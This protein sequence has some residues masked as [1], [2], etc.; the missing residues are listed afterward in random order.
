MAVEESSEEQKR[1]DA[2]GT[3]PSWWWR[4][5]PRNPEFR[6]EVESYGLSVVLHLLLLLLLGLVTLGGGGGSGDEVGADGSIAQSSKSSALSAEALEQI[7]KKQEVKPIEAQLPNPTRRRVPQMTQMVRTAPSQSVTAAGIGGGVGGGLGAGI[8]KNFGDFLGLLKRAG[9]DCVFVV[10]STGSM[11]YVINQT[12]EKISRLVGLIQK[13]V[14]VA[15]VGLVLYKDKGEDWVVRKSDL[16]FHGDK[17]RSFVSGIEADGGGDWEEGIKDGLEA[18][19]RDMSWRSRSKK[20]IVLVASSP[21][22]EKDVPAIQQLVAEFRGKGGVISTIDVSQP[23][24]IEFERA[25][26]ISIYGTPPEK[27]TELPPFYAE[28]QKALRGIARG[29]NGEMVALEKNEDIMRELMVVAFGKE[30]E[31]KV[32]Q[33]AQELES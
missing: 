3:R 28:I 14:P 9:F 19:V 32:A 4:F 6:E 21:P 17:L 23:A 30:W 24:H 18:A 33:Y 22:H 11:K 13:L 15:R 7:M 29:A 1:R 25:L 8:G 20:I 26:H 5:S 2:A 12:Q 16:T 31:S 27:I 10:D